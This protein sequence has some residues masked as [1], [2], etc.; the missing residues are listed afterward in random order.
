MSKED[1]ER[2][3]QAINSL[4]YKVVTIKQIEDI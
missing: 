3:I 4:D 1:I 2:A